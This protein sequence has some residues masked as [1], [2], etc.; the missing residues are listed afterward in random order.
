ML[1]CRKNNVFRVGDIK[2]SI[3]GFRHAKPAL[4]KGL[5]DHRG[6][7]DEVIYLIQ[8]LPF[9]ENDCRFQ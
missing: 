6:V 5:I 2:Q 3:Y 4:M 8:Q 1:I 7:Y 9:Q